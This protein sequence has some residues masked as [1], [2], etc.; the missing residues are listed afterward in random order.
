MSTKRPFDISKQQVCFSSVPRWLSSCLTWQIPA[1]NMLSVLKLQQ[2]EHEQK[3]KRQTQGPLHLNHRTQTS[4][5]SLENPPQ[6][7]KSN[8]GECM[9]HSEIFI[10]TF[11]TSQRLTERPSQL[12]FDSAACCCYWGLQGLT[13]ARLC[14]SGDQAPAGRSQMF[15]RCSFARSAAASFQTENQ[16]S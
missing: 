10:H 16:P 12:S 7:H 15:L 5:I 14:F 2:L 13:C 1:F 4:S 8:K 9:K 3:R 6:L 11:S